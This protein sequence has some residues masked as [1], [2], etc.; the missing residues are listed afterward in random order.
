M[1]CLSLS[2]LTLSVLF[3]A[4]LQAHRARKNPH[5]GKKTIAELHEVVGKNNQSESGTSLED[6]DS[7]SC[8]TSLSIS[9]AVF[10]C[11]FRVLPPRSSFIKLFYS[12]TPT[13]RWKPLCTRNTRSSLPNMWKME[14]KQPGGCPSR[15]GGPQFTIFAI[16]HF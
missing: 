6:H 12:I 7:A 5:T 14:W 1:L 11:S 16:F 8:S 10:I 13:W 15:E 9:L 4:Y 2:L 3:T